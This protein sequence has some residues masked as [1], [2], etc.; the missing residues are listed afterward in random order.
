MVKIRLLQVKSDES[1]S[2]ETRI[3]RVLAELP[4]HLAQADFV[5][6]PELWTIHAFNLNALQ[7]NALPLDAP[8]FKEFSHLASAAKSWLHAGSFPIQH[9][10]GTFT[11][12]AI[13]F[14]D[15]GMMHC[16]YS[17]IYL[18]GFIDGESKYLT[19][20]NKIA[21]SNTPLGVTGI[22]TC[23]DLRFP[24]LY[25]E[26]SARGAQT[27]LICAGWPTPRVEHWTTLLK[28]RAIENQSFVVATNGRGTFND[29]ALA[30]KSMVIDPKGHVIAQAG[31]DDEY[32]DAQINIDLVNQWRTE[33]PVQNDKRD[34]HTF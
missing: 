34:L 15:N 23:Y 12:T 17:K 25:R 1:E 32:V 29:I 5:V 19:A 10:D 20:G 9:Q 13:V 18:F 24:E 7:E 16:L 21:I 28:A 22:S 31:L 4:N 8:L 30:G 3:K 33:F 2:V 14:D 26:Q 27:F 11:N 6:L